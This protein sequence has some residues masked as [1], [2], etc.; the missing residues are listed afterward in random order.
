[1]RLMRFIRA[2]RSAWSHVK[3]LQKGV[4][5]L[6]DIVRVDQH[7]A[8]LELLGRAGELAQNERAILLDSARAIFLRYEI[9]SVL[10][11]RYEGD[12]ARSIV[13]KQIVAIE[14]PKVI[15]H[16]QPGVG[17]EA[18]VDVANQPV[19]ALLELVISGNSTRLGTTTWMR[20]TRPRSSG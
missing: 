3:C 2:V 15:L 4:G 11:R 5:H 8:R 18:A 20:T 17:R 1:M 7:R 6:L 10:E 12:V 19:D 16:R 14:A 9:H 13:R